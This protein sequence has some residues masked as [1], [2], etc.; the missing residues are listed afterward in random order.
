MGECLIY[1]LL[2]IH[3]GQALCPQRNED[4]LLELADA[5]HRPS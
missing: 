3:F 4:I 5:H 1:P 2:E